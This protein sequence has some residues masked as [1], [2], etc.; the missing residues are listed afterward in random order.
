MFDSWTFLSKNL[1]DPYVNML[2][3][4]VG[5]VPQDRIDP[6][7]QAGP[8]VLRGIMKHKVMK[9]CWQDHRDFYYVDTGYFGNE[10][11]ANNPDAHKLWHRIVRNDLQHSHII[12]RP[13]DRWQRFRRSVP[14]RHLG[15]RNIIVAAPD[16]KPCR[17]YGIDRQ[18][19]IDNTVNILQQHT[20]RPITVRQRVANRQERMIREPLTAALADA[21][22]LVTYNSL[23][24]V[25][26]IM[27]GVPVIVTAPV[28]AAQPVGS[29]DLT[30][31]EDPYWP[32][33]DLL[34]QWLCHLAY[35]QF[36][37]S[38]MRSGWALQQLAS[39]A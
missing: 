10:P 21:H 26:A 37:V 16:D 25:E 20:D 2:A 11:T 12:P 36:H 27:H 31:A 15:G 24:A 8:I 28:H 33:Q 39:P 30:T 22:L 9:Q 7:S 13:P 14:A 5:Q 32:D 35:A 34:Y 6:D 23:A 29:S 1:Q 17:F 3:H 18:Q 19:W 4:G 38:E